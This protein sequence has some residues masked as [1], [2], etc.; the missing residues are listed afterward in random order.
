MKKTF[1]L[2]LI[3]IILTNINLPCFAYEQNKNQIYSLEPNYK[4]NFLIAEDSSYNK[5]SIS[6]STIEQEKI[7]PNVWAWSFLFPGLGQFIMGEFGW[8]LFFAA[9]G[10]ALITL[11]AMVAGITLTA[12]GWA[13]L[14]LIG[15]DGP[16][17]LLYS[18]LYISN[19]INANQLNSSKSFKEKKQIIEKTLTDNP[20]NSWLWTTS[21][22]IPGSGQILYGDYL[23][24]VLFFI[25]ESLAVGTGVFFISQTQNQAI[26]LTSLGIFSGI[27]IWNI[28]DSFHISQ[29]KNELN[30]ITDK[31][32]EKEN[33]TELASNHLILKNQSIVYQVKF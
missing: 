12:G 18:F 16:A 24:G 6:N 31:S 19:L 25:L 14:A 7:N 22:V 33:V 2:T 27:H 8:G 1:L 13:I 17:T 11:I 30:K 15:I 3:I 9:S 29:E 28:I 26:A 20:L 32:N 21:I 10:L 23:R 4:S 5:L